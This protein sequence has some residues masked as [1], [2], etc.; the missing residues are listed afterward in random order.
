MT[1]TDQ[2]AWQYEDALFALMMQDV[3]EHE[4]AQILRQVKALEL[5]PAAAV[6]ELVDA[7]MEQSIH[8]FFARKKAKRYSGR[9]RSAIRKLAVAALVS[10]FLLTSAFA[11][12]EEFR[13]GALNLM[14]DVF[15][16]GTQIT[17]QQT[18]PQQQTI[19]R[20]HEQNVGFDLSV[21]WLPEGYV[22]DA[23]WSD[24]KESGVRYINEIGTDLDVTV[25]V[26]SESMMLLFD[27]EDCVKKNI[28]IQENE[29]T[30]YIKSEEAMRRRY[31]DNPEFI[32]DLTV[33]WCDDNAQTIVMVHTM[34][35]TEEET[36][37]LAET[38]RY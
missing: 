5:D 16:Q 7:R 22:L 6:P 29:A 14:I 10:S 9:M 26:Y 4:G 21:S 2:I 20:N 34:N 33:M 3:V 30:L 27:T 35:L 38:V 19:Q 36:I 32:S 13:V 28:L 25:D 18:E 23:E 24:A 1:R 31:P 37:K 17:F 12:S 15:D 11:Y 8:S